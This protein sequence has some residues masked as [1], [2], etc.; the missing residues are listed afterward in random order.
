[1]AGQWIAR[2][3]QRA[4]P[5]LLAPEHRYQSAHCGARLLPTG[6][7]Q[8][9]GVPRI[10]A[11]SVN[12]D[13]S[14]YMELMLRSLFAFNPELDGL[15]ITIL[16][17]NSTDDTRPL[18]DYA[19]AQGI[20]IA[21]TQWNAT[22]PANNHGENLRDFVLAHPDSEYILILD[23]DTMFLQMDTIQTM[24]SELAPQPE[25]WAVQARF[26][27]DGVNEWEIGSWCRG[28]EKK[29]LN[30]TTG[31][32]EEEVAK[33]LPLPGVP[34]PA[35]MGDRMYPCCALIRN[36]RALQLTAEHVGFSCAQ[37]H[38]SG[39]GKVYDT[40]GAA[41]QV[42]KTHGLHYGLSSKMVFHFG[43]VSYRPV[44]D[45]IRVRDI[46]LDR[47]RNGYSGDFMSDLGPLW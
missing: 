41:T 44:E 40:L 16:E 30:G 45:K 19:E 6:G 18:Y 11:V 27:A 13:T 2:V 14:P 31:N 26:T 33:G 24:A 9:R 15:D 36:S 23:C 8:L 37:F 5:W 3:A 25:W 20:A 21:R 42:M 34:L 39:G 7:S 47:L 35:V 10:K 28:G 17:N 38:E 46:L 32:S 4:G 12:Q 1:M 22:T 43:N 29:F